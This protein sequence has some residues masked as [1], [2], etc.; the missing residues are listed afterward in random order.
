MQLYKWEQVTPLFNYI[1]L[2]KNVH[3]PIKTF[4]DFELSI[5]RIISLDFD[6]LSQNFRLSISFSF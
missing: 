1:E 3:V 2:I 5:M 4:E 6:V